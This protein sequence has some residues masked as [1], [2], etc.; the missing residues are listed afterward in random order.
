ML[1][2]PNVSYE[3][4]ECSGTV[5]GVEKNLPNPCRLDLKELS[6][7]QSSIDFAQADVPRVCYYR[8]LYFFIFYSFIYYSLPGAKRER[9][10]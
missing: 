2:Y 1:D 4:F 10:G 7:P 8:H 5:H 6:A 3:N 9:G